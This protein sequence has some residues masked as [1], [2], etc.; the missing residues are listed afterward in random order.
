MTVLVTGSTG[1]V[2]RHVVEHLVR[3][4]HH[5]RALTRDPGHASFPAGVEVVQGNLADPPS[6]ATALDGVTGLHL[7]TFDTGG[8]YGPANLETGP[9]LLDL[10]TKAG[11]QRVTVLRGGQTSPVQ[12]AIQASGLDW[13][14]IG[15]VEFMSGTLQ[16]A[17]SV[18][19]EGVVRE[20][21]GDRL[22]ATVH[23]SDIG[24]VTATCLVEKGHAGKVYTLTGPEALTTRQKVSILARVVE[25]SIEFVEL[26]EEQAKE[27]WRAQGMP[28]ALVDFLMSAYGNTPPEG[29]TVVPTVEE[30]TGRPAR[31][32]AEWAAENR[33]A[34]TA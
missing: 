18:R 25:R 15:P 27:R 17:E 20:P 7:I 29:Y 30:I 10:A 33:A 31:T 21:F 1:T 3:G 4:G 26:T 24:A 9:Q 32:F 14:V 2:G 22:S 23:E 5:V 13:T 34:F 28:D 11:V 8:P 16:W 6:I 12:E 19:T